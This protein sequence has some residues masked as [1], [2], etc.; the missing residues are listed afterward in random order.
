MPV[1]G[2]QI[3]LCDLPVHFD[4]YWGCSH[5]C[6]YCFA[7]S[8]KNKRRVIKGKE[9]VV[10][11]KYFISGKR[12]LNTRWCD[13]DIPIHWGG[14]SD[15]FQP[16]EKESGRSLKCLRLFAETGYPF[17]FSTKG[18]LIVE[19]PYIDVLQD[20]NVVAQVSMLSPRY[21][22]IELG[23]PPYA[24]RL[25]MVEKLA[26]VAHRVIV[27]A[28]PYS[29][30]LLDDI[31]AALPL[32]ASAGVYGVSF[33]GM[34][35]SRKKEGLVK[36]GKDWC[37]PVEKLERDYQQIRDAC[38][39]NRL[40]FLCAENRLR[41]KMSDDLCCCGVGGLEGFETNIANLNH[42][43]ED[44]EIEYTENMQQVGTGGTFRPLVQ[45]TLLGSLVT[46]Q[47]SYADCMEIVKQ[48][49]TY[50]EVMGLSVGM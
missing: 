45:N 46:H 41:I 44:G 17:A 40:V 12:T 9:S 42:M 15:P 35:W 37:F 26:S 8:A 38:H 7:N 48:S 25:I 20:C 2:S 28:Q 19:S 47:I 49:K 30:G 43:T 6:T 22:E 5:G 39:D 29:L 11:L 1:S 4:T 33:E 24:K 13:W 50:R 31:L 16:I 32:Y 3:V 14:L 10:A 34:K 18:A 23:A 27:R 21:D 36:V